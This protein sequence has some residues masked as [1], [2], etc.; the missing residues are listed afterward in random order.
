MIGKTIVEVILRKLSV[1]DY[2]KTYLIHHRSSTMVRME[3]FAKEKGYHLSNLK[4]GVLCI[5]KYDRNNNKTIRIAQRH[6]V[7]IYDMINYFEYYFNAVEPLIIDG[8]ECVDYSIPKEH[9]LKHSGLKFYFNS[10]PESDETTN[11]YL[12]KAMIKEGMVVFDLGAYC[13]ATSYFF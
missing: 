6:E 13:G 7:Y 11:V 1:L 3:S 8:E 12:E 9:I 10:L 2:C 4:N 5:T